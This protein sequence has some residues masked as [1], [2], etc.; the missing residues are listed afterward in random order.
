MKKDKNIFY[1]ILRNLDYPTYALHLTSWM[2]YFMKDTAIKRFLQKLIRFESEDSNLLLKLLSGVDI[3]KK[4]IDEYKPMWQF[5]WSVRF[6]GTCYERYL[7]GD[8]ALYNVIDKDIL[9]SLKK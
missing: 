4:T 9:I 2:V 3:D 6:N 8:D 1:K 5:R 7:K